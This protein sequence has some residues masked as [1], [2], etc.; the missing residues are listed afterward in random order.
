[1]TARTRRALTQAL[2]QFAASY[3]HHQMDVIRLGP[4]HQYSVSSL[5]N[6]DDRMRAIVRR[7]TQVERRAIKRGRALAGAARCAESAP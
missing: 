1:M 5:E 6:Y 4:T 2:G 3:H 7:I